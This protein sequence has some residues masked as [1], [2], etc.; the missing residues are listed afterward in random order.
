MYRDF[1]ENIKT[2]WLKFLYV[3]VVVFTMLQLLTAFFQLECTRRRT[4]SKAPLR[5]VFL[6]YT[7][8]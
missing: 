4:Y 7:L 5:N 3:A 8:E 6:M 1:T 2:W